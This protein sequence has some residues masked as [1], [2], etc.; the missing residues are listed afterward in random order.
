L[1]SEG[2]F[3]SSNNE[4]IQYLCYLNMVMTMFRITAVDI[5]Y[6]NKE[7][8][9]EAKKFLHSDWFFQICSNMNLDPESTKLIIL[10]GTRISSR[11]KYE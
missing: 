5:K 11:S 8:R 7:V 10:R 3:D 6:G 9:H 1:G 2:F 4:S